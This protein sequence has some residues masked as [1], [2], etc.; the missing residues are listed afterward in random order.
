MTEPRHEFDVAE[1]LRL[2]EQR[3]ATFGARDAKIETHIRSR[4]AK[5]SAWADAVGPS[6][7]GSLILWSSGEVDT[8]VMRSGDETLVVNEHRLIRT[9]EEL[10]SVFA[11][12]ENAVTHRE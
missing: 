7:L 8:Q 1:L 9:S 12:F 11:L 6:R 5:P 4:G 3:Y 10:R 2:A